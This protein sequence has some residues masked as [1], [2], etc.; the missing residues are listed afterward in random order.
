MHSTIL[1]CATYELVSLRLNVPVNNFSVM[2][3]RSQSSWVLQYFSGS[4]CVFVQGH[5]MAEVGIEPPDLSFPSQRLP[6]GP[7]L[8][9]TDE[10]QKSQ[11]MCKISTLIKI[12][13]VWCFFKL[14]RP[15]YYQL[16]LNLIKTTLKT[17]FS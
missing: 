9:A 1:A 8:P 14:A 4:K 3:G 11:K 10:F 16:H 7:A 12:S 15:V 2:S 17:N 13:S 6:L 5:N